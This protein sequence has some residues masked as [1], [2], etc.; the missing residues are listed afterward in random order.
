ML[1]V[2]IEKKVNS[3]RLE[4]RFSIGNEILVILGKSGAGKSLTLNCI[5]GIIKPDKGMIKL[6]NRILFDSEKN[7]NMP[8]RKRK[9]AYLFQN[10]ALFPHKR[11]IDNIAYA[12]SMKKA[13]SIMQKFGIEKLK[14]RFPHEISGGERQRVALARAILAEPELLL[15]DEPLSALDQNT[16]WE[17]ISFIK[18]L[19]REQRLPLIY[20]THDFT[21]AVAI[22][23]KAGVIINGKLMQFGEREEVFYKP[24]TREIAE[25]VGTENIFEAELLRED[26]EKSSFNFKGI[27]I[28]VNKRDGKKEKK[29]MAKKAILC[30]RPE[31]I[32][33]IRED[34]PKRFENTYR[35]EIE[36]LE[37]FGNAL[38][39]ITA[40]I[41]KNGERIKI[42]VPRHV[43]EK[44]EIREG[45]KIEVSFKK[46]KI[47]VI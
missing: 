19:Q 6:N 45:K 39:K 44:M 1:E 36:A 34:K 40:K 21:E 41:E 7:I 14:D 8:L 15:L 43:R 20:V 26:N 18:N 46:E 10:L 42:L 9:I 27:D 47:H 2:D 23:D 4:V 5:S 33:L 24:E 12:G 13:I 3:F 22:A 35:A 25:L 32:M 37:N 28:I 16:K 30:I 11:V 38:V 17:I 31:D 29:R